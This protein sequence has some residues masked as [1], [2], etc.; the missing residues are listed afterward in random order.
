MKKFLNIYTILYLLVGIFGTLVT[1]WF[2]PLN[3]GPLTVPPSSWL[4]GFSFLLITLIQ[5]HYG[6]KVSGKMIWILLFLTALLCI[7]LNYTLML[8]LASG[9]AFVA[10]Q[11]VTKG[12][13]TFGVRRSLSSM[14]GSVVD[15]GI[16]VFLG[17][18]PLGVNTV[19]WDLYFQTVLGQVLVQLV[20]QGIAG[21]I[22]DHYFE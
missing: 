18:S 6:P 16:W 21:Q 15:V 10:G 8:V 11:Y 14:I 22:Y 2:L 17:L 19:P 3:I 1:V 5:D 9:V 13:Y 7:S 20:L 4:M 12:L